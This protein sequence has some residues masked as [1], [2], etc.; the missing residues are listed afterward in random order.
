M[1]AESAARDA[2]ARYTVEPAIRVGMGI[3][4]AVEGVVPTYFGTTG[5]WTS[6]DSATLRI[7]PDGGVVASVGISTAGQGLTSGHGKSVLTSVWSI[8]ARVGRPV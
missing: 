7:D 8:E 6:H 4:T 3:A 5:H 1:L 2:R